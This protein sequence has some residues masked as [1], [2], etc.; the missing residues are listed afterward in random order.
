MAENGKTRA[1][2][3]TITGV[4]ENSTATGVRIEGVW[5]TLPRDLDAPPPDRGA[6][7]ELTVSDRHFVRG[8]RTLEPAPEPAEADRAVVRASVLRSAARFAGTHAQPPRSVDTLDLAASFEAWVYRPM[9]K[10]QDAG[11]IEIPPDR[12]RRLKRE[13]AL[14]SVVEFLANKPEARPEHVLVLAEAWERWLG[15]PRDEDAV[16]D[17]AGQMPAE[18]ALADGMS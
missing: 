6:R 7:V 13:S 10:E 2:T 1:S 11:R 8:L 12:E 5:Y 4:V 15:R 14:S 18:G 17:S 3:S 16:G 9:V